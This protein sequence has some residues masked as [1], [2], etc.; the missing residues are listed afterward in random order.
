MPSDVVLIGPSK[1]GKTTLARLLALRLAI[2]YR[3][4]DDARW[5]YMREI[6]YDADLDRTIR[7]A[8]GFLARALYWQL[9]GA[10]VVERF[11]EENAGCVLDFGA[12]HTVYDSSEHLARV[13]RALS[14]YPNVFLILPSP[15]PDESVRTLNQR[16]LDEGIAFNFDF[17]AHFVRHRSNYLLAK[18]I[19]YTNGKTP[20]QTV[21]E[22]IELL[23]GLPLAS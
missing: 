10:Y 17:S 4:L 11:L 12:G 16:L 3:S 2:E 7:A 15:D 9:F 21:D 20:Q 8:G 23:D 5:R 13:E 1:A 22:V 18:H 6:G 14:S 19:V